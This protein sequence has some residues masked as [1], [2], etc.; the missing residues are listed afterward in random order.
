MKVNKERRKVT[1]TTGTL[2][3]ESGS[4]TTGG[5]GGYGKAELRAV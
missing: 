1:L 2:L 5:V 4:F 3:S